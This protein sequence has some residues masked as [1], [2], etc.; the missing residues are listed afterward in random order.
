MKNKILLSLL[1]FLT[2]GTMQ[3]SAQNFEQVYK[4]SFPFKPGNKTSSDDR[5]FVYGACEKSLAMLD[6]NT[7]KLLWQYD[8]L[9]S[10]GKKV[11]DYNRYVRQLN[12]AFL[13]SKS[14]KKEPSL[15]VCIDGV[16]GMELWRTTE[17]GTEYEFQDGI[18][19]G[20]DYDKKYFTVTV[21]D[22]DM[23]VDVMT[24]KILSKDAIAAIKTKTKQPLDLNNL[25]GMG[26]RYADIAFDDA[27]TMM[28]SLDYKGITNMKKIRLSASDYNTGA[29]KWEVNFDGTVISPICKDYLDG[30]I[31][32]DDMIGMEV[33]G[34]YAFVIY[35]GIACIDIR[36]GK[37]VWEKKLDN[38][39]ASAG[40]RAKQVLGISAV[41]LIT[42][43]AVYIVDLSSGENNLKKIDIS[44]GN[45]I[46]KS[47]KIDN[48]S[49]VPQLELSGNVLLA[50]FGGLLEE[51][52]YVPGTSGNPDVY[53]R[54][55]DWAGDGGVRGYDAATGKIIWDTK[56]ILK[57]DK[58]DRTT[59][60]IVEGA[61]VYFSSDNIFYKVDVATG[62]AAYTIDV[63][64]FK[65]GKMAGFVLYKNK[66]IIS[67]DEGIA[68][69]D[70]SN[71]NKFYATNTG[72]NY[73]NELVSNTN[74]MVWTGSKED[75]WDAFALVDINTGTILG[76][77]KS[78]PY[79]YFDESGNS[80][81]KFDGD[82]VM[83]FKAAGK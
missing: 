26:Y 13:Y 8:I 20:M 37:L 52:I 36:T 62:K 73:G 51:Q 18:K 64:L 15:K 46:W 83:R 60:M 39:D 27:H 78:T 17:L 3:I 65:V 61:N 70:P 49:R 22:V 79:P 35:E 30:L 19:Y 48:D 50:R 71:G 1:C 69:L 80:F 66:L 54:K 68:A 16:T 34:N 9:K 33:H 75:D 24:G 32:D 77:M 57:S 11:M 14:N 56:S 40:L 28:L 45:V 81:I 47:D 44:T 6:G 53:K 23:D 5:N 31:Y 43:D 25:F 59:A 58:F 4:V 82:E 29:D 72:N 74:V 12:I 41:P 42:K 67:C 10:T 55:F 38:A 63:A 2:V 76:K 21:N 7:G